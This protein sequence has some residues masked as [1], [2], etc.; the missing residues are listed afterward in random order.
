MGV[1][2]P[3][4]YYVASTFDVRQD[5]V[6]WNVFKANAFQLVVEMAGKLK[7]WKL[8]GALSAFTDLPNS[9][10]H[11]W[12]VDNAEALVDGKHYSEDNQQ[13]FDNVMAV[14]DTSSVQ[15]LETMPYDP[16]FEP[17]GA[18]TPSPS[19]DGRF[20]F[21]WVE[22]TLRPGTETRGT[23]VNACKSLL[24]R[25]ETGL[26]TWKLL[27]A[28]STVTGRPNT[29][30]HLWLLDDANALLDGMNWFGENNPDYVQLAKC[31][32]RQRQQ[33]FTSMLYN[34]LGQ[35][36]TLS[37]DDTKHNQKFKELMLTKGVTNV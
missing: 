30:M 31:C 12:R 3:K 28:A 15:L 25:M 7:S 36:G 27:A 22:L 33:L 34:P 21:L 32:L 4:R 18:S 2:V 11:L 26:P 35:N 6:S 19:K 20:Y 23:F 37:A 16:H 24:K 14:S 17:K 5:D 9:V 8:F 13:L 29:V 10:L 1:T